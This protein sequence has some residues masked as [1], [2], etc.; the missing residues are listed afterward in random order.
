MP[1]SGCAF[2]FLQRCA[3]LIDTCASRAVS[4]RGG[5]LGEKLLELSPGLCPGFPMTSSKLVTATSWCLVAAAPA[6]AFAVVTADLTR[7]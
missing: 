1:G 3:F 4:E 5:D 6:G 2:E 7:S